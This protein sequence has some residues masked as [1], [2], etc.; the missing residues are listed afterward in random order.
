MIEPGR[1]A[2]LRAPALTGLA[3]ACAWL[4]EARPALR[5]LL[6]RHGALSLSGL[7]IE[8]TEDFATVRDALVDERAGYKEKATPR[9]AFG[10]DVFSSTDLPPAQAI[11]MHNEN[12]YTLTFPGLL[13]FC[14]LEAPEEGGAT[15]V[16]DCREVLAHL[17]EHLVRRFRE[18]GWLLE[19]TY[20]DCISLGWREA[21]ATTEKAQVERYCDENRIGYQWTGEDDLRTSQLRSAVV[22]HPRTGQ[23]VWFNHAAF[24]NEWSLDP[25]VRDVLVSEAGPQGLPFNTSLGDG[26]PLS[27]DDVRELNRAYEKATVRRR[28]APGDLL[29]VDNVL[30]THG[31]D[32]FRG[33]RRIAVAMGEPLHVESCAPTVAPAP[34]R[35]REI[36]V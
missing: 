6:D 2:T 4:Q 12:S 5:S 15:P 30:S 16:A 36:A 33:D 11:R 25:E 3:D 29:I 34:G 18:H 21:F 27:P 26:T 14:C 7:P 24:W 19:R 23:E 20:S 22:T 9:S 35:T 10:N 32:P 17:P 31:R 8:D 1:P 28:W 13:L